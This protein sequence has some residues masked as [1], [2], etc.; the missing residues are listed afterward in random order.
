MAYRGDRESLLLR[1]K[2]LELELQRLETETA[3][4]HAV[5][6]QLTD[7]RTML[8]RGAAAVAASPLNVDELG[9]ASPCTADWNRMV[10]DE[11]KRFCEECGQNVFNV[12]ALSR[13][14]V[15]ALVAQSYRV[16]L[17]LFRRTDGTV[18]TTDCPVGRRRVRL[19][20]VATVVGGGVLA[21]VAAA[22]IAHAT[23]PAPLQDLYSV[24]I[25]GHHTL[26]YGSNGMVHMSGSNPVF[27]PP[28]PPTTAPPHPPSN[29]EGHHLMGV[30][31]PPDRPNVRKTCNYRRL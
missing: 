11:R 21:G 27:E 16:C 10:G 30:V 7:V 12:E 18:L 28:K 31:A 17:R 20:Q 13:E 25:P 4:L 26:D 23:R 14:E 6:Q 9:I 2:E 24:E 5:R 22:A 3:R 15:A 1:E 8:S 19:K 29:G